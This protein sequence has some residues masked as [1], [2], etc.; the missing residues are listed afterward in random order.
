MSYRLW[1]MTASLLLL[2]STIAAQTPPSSDVWLASLER[3]GDSLIVGTPRNI[4]QRAGYDNQPSFMPDSKAILYTSIREDGQAD[5][6]RF[7]IASGATTRMTS[8]PES[9]YSATVTPDGRFFSVIRVERDS[10]Q[11]LWKFPLAGGEPSL[12]LENVKPV[13]YHAWV[14]DTTLALF[15]LG[16]P[17][18]LHIANTRTG[19]SQERAQAI[20]RAIQRLPRGHGISYVEN[21]CRT[22]NAPDGRT[23]DAPCIRTSTSVTELL[24]V[25]PLNPGQSEWHAWYDQRTLLGSSESSILRFT[26]LPL[27]AGQCGVNESCQNFA[28]RSLVTFD[29]A[30]LRNVTRLAT[31]PDGRWLAFVAE[32]AAPA[33]R[34]DP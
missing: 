18:S 23:A 10:T 6:Y 13:G 28:W 34:K 8:T 1:A 17:A 4:T 5:I 11:R 14:D 15:V 29:G 27:L 19:M 25:V 7:D 22:T 3:R 20:G 24:S 26:E 21:R 32:P 2:A 31:S 33:V 16:R 30:Q 12:V 9:E